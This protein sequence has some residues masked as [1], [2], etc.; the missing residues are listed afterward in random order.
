VT[1]KTD[2]DP[3]WLKA[4]LLPAGRASYPHHGS[5][6]GRGPNDIAGEMYLESTDLRIWAGEVVVEHLEAWRDVPGIDRSSDLGRGSRRGALGSLSEMYLESTGLRIWSGMI[7]AG[8]RADCLGQIFSGAE[9]FAWMAGRATA[10]GIPATSPQHG[11]SQRR[12]S[13]V[14]GRARCSRVP[15]GLN[16]Y[17]VHRVLV[18]AKRTGNFEAAGGRAI[19]LCTWE[20]PGSVGKRPPTVATVAAYNPQS[21]GKV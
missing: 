5:G 19:R 7:D 15:T 9:G 18:T 20:I 1:G 14:S 12:E 21:A 10:A 17:G 6:T 11:Y 2:G 13:T 8:H 16:P 4:W 3:C